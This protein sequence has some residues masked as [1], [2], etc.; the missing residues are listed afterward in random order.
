MIGIRKG[1]ASDSLGLFF[2]GP[3]TCLAPT[4]LWL[5][6]VALSILATLNFKCQDEII[7]HWVGERRQPFSVD[8]MLAILARLC[9]AV[10]SADSRVGGPLGQVKGDI[11]KCGGSKKG[12]D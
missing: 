3:L 5:S 8:L 12:R 4:G 7:A 11:C 2:R 10:C 1:S 6:A 9:L